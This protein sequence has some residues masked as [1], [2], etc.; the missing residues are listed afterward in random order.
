MEELDLVIVGAGPTGLFATFCAGLRE[1]D[2]VTLESLD[3]IGGQIPKFYPIKM[4]YD[5]AGVLGATGNEL[6][7]GL[8]AQTKIFNKKIL[9]NSRVTDIK[10]KDDGRFE[11]E[12]NEKPTYIAKTI[13]LATGIGS[14]LPKKLGVEGEEKYEGNGVHYVVKNLNDYYKKR[15]AV[16]GGGDAGFDMANQV[17]GVADKVIVIEFLDRLRAAESSISSLKNSGK[18]EIFT[19]TKVQRIQGNENDVEK[20]TV[21]DLNSDEIRDVDVD[22]V[23][24]AIGHDAKP[25]NF[26][27]LGLDTFMN[28]YIKV[29]DRQETSLPGIFAAG[30]NCQTKKEIKLALLAVCFSEAYTALDNIKKY[31]SPSGA[32]PSTHSTEMKIKNQ[33]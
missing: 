6:A 12:V 26:R 30:D 3:V 21:K 25:G 32:I 24:V 17:S 28:R 23:I 8:E 13:L 20:I 16:I 19:K 9:L 10:E 18:Y 2:S 29:N 5:V 22:A 31:L 14:L 33:A 1:I 7:A 4:V 27:S 15:V 11:I